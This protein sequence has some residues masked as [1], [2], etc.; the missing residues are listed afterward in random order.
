MPR[1][2]PELDESQQQEQQSRQPHQLLSLPPSSSAV[3]LQ[4]QQ[5]QQTLNRQQLHTPQGSTGPESSNASDAPSIA[6]HTPN[7]ELSQDAA[8]QGFAN[9]GSR[10]PHRQVLR[11]DGPPP[12]SF[13][14]PALGRSEVVDTGSVRSLSAFPSPPTHFPI[15]PMGLGS[16]SPLSPS[17][18]SRA[19]STGNVTFPS[20]SSQGTDDDHHHYQQQQQQNAGYQDK[21]Y[22]TGPSRQ[23][24]SSPEQER[25]PIE[26]HKKQPVSSGREDEFGV[27][28][29]NVNGNG[30]DRYP[31]RAV[32]AAVRSKGLERNDTGT[33]N[34]SYVAAM[35]NKYSNAQ[36]VG[37][38]HTI[39]SISFLT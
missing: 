3:D 2:L 39:V 20:S 4:Q 22:D 1:D 16:R 21:P 25:S 30:G 33:S 9:V 31:T 19:N 5:Q 23:L 13:E 27:L 14:P 6:S 37:A 35:R 12:S 36:T 7:D 24:T 38:I 32:D 8:T 10:S 17:P 28:N 29:R 26:D 15:P 18:Q 11:R 34:E